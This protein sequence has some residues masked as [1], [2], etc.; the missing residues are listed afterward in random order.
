MKAK[1]FAAML[2]LCSLVAFTQTAAALTYNIDLNTQTGI[3]GT[4][5]TAGWITNCDCFSY[6]DFTPVFSVQPGSTVNFGHINIS[7]FQSGGTPDAGPF[8]PRNNS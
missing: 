7:A 1:L 6:I 2:A 5:G 4:G 8:Q 3:Q